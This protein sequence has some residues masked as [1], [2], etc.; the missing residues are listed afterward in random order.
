MIHTKKI[1]L[2]SFTLGTT[3][4][5]NVGFEAIRVLVFHSSKSVPY[6]NGANRYL[7]G[8]VSKYLCTYH[9]TEEFIIALANYV[10]S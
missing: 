3:S 2:V 9:R 10:V 7:L 1:V 5:E 6:Q 4:Q 8:L